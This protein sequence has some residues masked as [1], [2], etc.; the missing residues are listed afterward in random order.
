VSK[1]TLISIDDW[2][3]VYVNGQLVAEGHSIEDEQAFRLAQQYGPVT[4][5]ESHYV[6]DDEWIDNLPGSL[7]KDLT[8]VPLAV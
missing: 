5:V 1:F 3:G 4:S 6:N 8:E 2:T 7:P